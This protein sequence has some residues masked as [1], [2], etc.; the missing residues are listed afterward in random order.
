MTKLK[1]RVITLG[2]VIPVKDQFKELAVLLKSLTQLKRPANMKL[3]ITVVNDGSNVAHT[4]QLEKLQ[5]KGIQVIHNSSSRGFAFCVNQ[6]CAKTPAD[7]CWVLSPDSE[8][9]SP[10]LLNTINHLCMEGHQL[11][12]GHE[13][14]PETSALDKMLNYRARKAGKLSP[15]QAIRRGN[16]VVN[17]NQF[18]AVGGFDVEMGNGEL[19]LQDFLRRFRETVID[20]EIV[21]SD[22]LLVRRRKGVDLEAWLQTGYMDGESISDSFYQRYP[23]YYGKSWYRWFDIYMNQGLSSHVVNWLHPFS[24]KHSGLVSR[25]AA[26]KYFPRPL[27]AA[28]LHWLWL[29]RYFEGTQTREQMFAESELAQEEVAQ[30]ADNR[31]EKT[32]HAA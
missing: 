26:H 21:V 22:S 3:G 30:L 5:S 17:R 2:I 28:T 18:F 9:T 15:Q 31:V 11:I 27:L 29:L 1:A 32:K 6:G 4:Q 25:M 7:H 8:F 23:T 12:L 10:L 24:L 20:E 14:I 16:L 19:L 13:E